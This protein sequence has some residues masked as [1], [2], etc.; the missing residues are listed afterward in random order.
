M[1]VALKLR[2]IGYSRPEEGKLSLP[3]CESSSP[4][5]TVEQLQI[6]EVTRFL[7]KILGR[8]P[9]GVDAYQLG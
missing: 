2:N 4:D 3:V 9:G 1:N 8:R 5:E 6:W 7:L